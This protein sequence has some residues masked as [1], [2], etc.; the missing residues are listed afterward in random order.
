M[1]KSA[2]AEYIADGGVDYDGHESDVHDSYLSAL[3]TTTFSLLESRALRQTTLLLTG[4]LRW[5]T[6]TST[7]Y[8]PFTRYC[9]DPR[10]KI[11]GYQAC[12]APQER[13]HVD[14]ELSAEQA[15][16]TLPAEELQ[17]SQHNW[18]R[19]AKELGLKVS[20]DT[21]EALRQASILDCEKSLLE[22]AETE[23]VSL[24]VPA[25]NASFHA[26]VT[27]A[28]QECFPEEEDPQDDSDYED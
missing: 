1:S 25:R 14:Y 23:G 24:T 11:F 21:W 12:I 22:I 16:L 8:S 26:K 18:L 5:M 13:L 2:L 4:R 28:W 17:A 7:I 6:L 9:S 3:F 15:F 27:T 19:L 10:D 20:S